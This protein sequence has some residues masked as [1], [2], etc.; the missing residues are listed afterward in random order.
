MATATGKPTESIIKIKGA[1]KEAMQ[2]AGTVA[3]GMDNITLKEGDTR[4]R[5]LPP[6]ADANWDALMGI[7]QHYV[8]LDSDHKFYANCPKMYR[9]PCPI[10][11]Y[12]EKAV[13]RTDD[14][15]LQQ[16]ADQWKANPKF[17][18]VAIV[19]GEEEL[20]PRVLPIG[21]KV[22]QFLD[23]Q[24]GANGNGD[25]ANPCGPDDVASGLAKKLGYSYAGYD[26]IISR[27]GS[28]TRTQYSVS[29]PRGC[30][31]VSATGGKKLDIALFNRWVQN[32]PNLAEKAKVLSFAEL[33]HKLA[34]ESGHAAALPPAR[35]E[36]ASTVQD[37]LRR[38]AI[39]AEFTE[40]ETDDEDDIP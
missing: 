7:R 9:L 37:D 16:R 5:I 3:G 20:G 13:T 35:F 22:K 27:T 29:T 1:T 21:W 17:L 14:A 8:E 25:F 38:N 32:S 23:S 28:G 26:I 15:F 40:G 11:A 12:V 31:D 30:L 10:C 4:V 39:D 6:S 19:R 18:A 36:Q 24:L 2:K 34:G 33:E